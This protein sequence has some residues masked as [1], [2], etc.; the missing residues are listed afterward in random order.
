MLQKIKEL[1][2]EWRGHT[3]V[4]VKRENID[5]KSR[6]ITYVCKCCGRYMII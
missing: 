5:Y 6:K 1:I 3:W 2:C 4:V